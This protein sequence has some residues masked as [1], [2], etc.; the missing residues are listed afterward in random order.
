MA[1]A[2]PNPQHQNQPQPQAQQPEQSYPY[3][4]YDRPH[5]SQIQDHG[6]SQPVKKSENA[7]NDATTYY[8]PSY[9]FTITGDE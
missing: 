8:G 3:P 1:D 9:P 2:Q 7:D 5:L 4:L 6:I